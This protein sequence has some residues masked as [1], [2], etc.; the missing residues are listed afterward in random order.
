MG[1]FYG[2]QKFGQNMLKAG[3]TFKSPTSRT[4]VANLRLAGGHLRDFIKDRILE[5]GPGWTPLSEVTIGARQRH[6][7]G[8][9]SPADPLFYTSLL[10]ESVDAVVTGPGVV[11]VGVHSER[12]GY[13][14]FG[15][16]GG[17]TTEDVFYWNDTG[18]HRNLPARPLISDE[19][20]EARQAEVAAVFQANM[21][22]AVQ[23]VINGQGAV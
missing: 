19:K 17:A 1:Q 7:H 11:E 2:F 4:T 13:S 18:D 3:T 20:F 9:G 21:V 14:Q 16:T 6:G 5:G 10:Y 8:H 23:R 15:G 12:Y 22:R